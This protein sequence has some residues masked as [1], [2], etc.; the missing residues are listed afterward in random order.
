MLAR[1]LSHPVGHC[2]SQR[3]SIKFHDQSVDSKVIRVQSEDS[4]SSEQ[5]GTP[6]C[7]PY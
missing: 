5:I 4:S 7:V 2:E 3:P 1:G 6:H